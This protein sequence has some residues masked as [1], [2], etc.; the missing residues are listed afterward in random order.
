VDERARAAADRAEI[1]NLL[2]R[3]AIA[4]DTRDWELLASCFVPDVVYRFAHVG[5]VEGIDGV[6]EICRRSLD[7][8]DASQ[9]LIASP[10]VEVHGDEAR[11]RCSFQAQHVREGLEGGRNFVVAGTY[12]DRLRRTEDGWR[13]VRRELERTWT[14]G[15]PAVLA[16]SATERASQAS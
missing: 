9:H 12:V 14:E 5:D 4:L 11:S 16:H 13:I 15:N 6:V 2:V 3:Y 8:L 10:Y 1:E 7:P